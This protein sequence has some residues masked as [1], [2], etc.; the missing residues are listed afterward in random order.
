MFRLLARVTLVAAALFMAPAAWAQ[1]VP[2]EVRG[3][4]SIGG[5]TDPG[6]SLFDPDRIAEA[7]VELLY[8]LPGIG[9]LGLLGEVRPHLGGTLS[10]S[11]GEHL[12]Y[13]GL[14][15]TFRPPVLPV[16]G[17]A[18]LGGAWQTAS[19]PDAPQRFG[20]PA[21]GRAAATLGVDVLPG[22]S[23]MAT[24]SHVS[25]FGACGTPD[26]GRTDALLRVGIRF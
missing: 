10:F 14:S 24:V 19:D 12:V 7:N 5:V 21:L 20:C 8:S 18:S 16:F 1:I 3:G 4:V 25:D 17:E 26:N 23:I 11:G 13:A 6:T 2:F 15:W 22:A 9:D